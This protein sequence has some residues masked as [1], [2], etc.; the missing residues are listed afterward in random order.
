MKKKGFK[1]TYMRYVLFM[2]LVLL[3]AEIMVN[4]PDQ[5]IEIIGLGCLIILSGCLIV[6]AKVREKI[7]A[8]ERRK[9]DL[10]NTENLNKSNKASYLLIKKS[11]QDLDERFL[12]LEK[13]NLS[14]SNDLEVTEHKLQKAMFQ[15][16]EE[17][18]KVARITVGR[19]KENAEAI[20]NSNMEMKARII[21][22]EESLNALTEKI[23]ML[24]ETPTDT[25]NRMDEEQYQQLISSINGLQQELKDYIQMNIEQMGQAIQTSVADSIQM[26]PQA[27]IQ[28]VDAVSPIEEMEEPQIDFADSMEEELQ[29]DFA[30]SME[31]EPQIDFAEGLEEEPEL[32]NLEQDTE[33]PN[34]MM[35]LDDIAA[36]LA[37]VGGEEEAPVP[38]PEPMME[39]MIPELEPMMEE[40][41]PELESMMEETI[42]ELEPIM[43]D[44]APEPEL[45]LE[46][47]IPEPEPMLE[48]AIPEPEP[49]VEEALAPE[50]EP[51]MEEAPAPEPEMMMEETIPELE[52]IMEEAPAPE[53]EPIIEEA[54]APDFS[55]PN[56]VM[57]PD[58]IAALLASM[59]GGEA[60]PE[61]EPEPIQ[62]P[63]NPVMPDLSNPNKIMSP[64]EIAA[65]IAGI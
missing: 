17:D 8:E 62:D 41:I 2:I 44:A 5:W 61:P 34:K 45:L 49:I 60:V 53:P 13:Q 46:E 28:N 54:P 10:E 12:K 55:D 23:G 36:L 19:N 31:E 59:G 65:L 14:M 25:S 32:I 40:T 57:G 22:F 6:A 11:F 1:G 43:E 48:E 24:A 56:K 21:G 15:M 64:D 37:S 47:A 50:P 51:I 3:E 9:E 27:P 39:D 33:D 20:I 63:I 30:D 4:Y 18:K 52:P 7:E 35:G 58:D 26:I 29:V 42:P 16:M 38:E